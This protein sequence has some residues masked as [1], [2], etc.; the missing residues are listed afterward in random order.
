MRSR[1]EK[2]RAKLFVVSFLAIIAVL[3]VALPYAHGYK[4]GGGAKTG[5]VSLVA[6]GPA[7]SKLVKG[8][9]VPGRDLPKKVK[10]VI[11]AANRI[12]HKPYVYGGGHGSF[13]SS[14]YD[15]SGAVSFALR[16]GKFLSRPLA[17]G[18]LMS[19]GKSGKG[20]HITVYSNPGHVYLVV[21]GLRFDTAMTPGDGPGWSKS[22]RSTSGSFV[23]RNPGRGF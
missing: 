14:G 4:K 11:R 1:E 23:A 19:W 18:P 15:C 13:R 6:K 16:G 3:A 21:D 7:K 8:K 17:S 12:E 22:L 2:V 5:G 20:R 10:K 9:A